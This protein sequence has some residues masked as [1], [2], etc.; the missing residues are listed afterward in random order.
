MAEVGGVILFASLLAGIVAVVV[1]FFSFQQLFDNRIFH[2]APRVW[3]GGN[4][5][6]G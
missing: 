5:A 6:D 2:G 1:L 4:I 3:V